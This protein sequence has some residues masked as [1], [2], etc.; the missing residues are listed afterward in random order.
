MSGAGVVAGVRAGISAVLAGCLTAA[1]TGCALWA[2]S[3]GPDTPEREEP[4]PTLAA[5]PPPGGW[6]DVHSPTGLVYSVPP[7]WEVGDPFGAP[8][9]GDTDLPQDPGSDWG[10]GYVTTANAIADRGYCAASGLSFRTL[11]GISTMLPGDAR[12]QAESASR[13]MADSI[14][15]RFTRNG[16]DVPVPEARS[17]GVSGV[18]AWYVSLRGAVR[19]PRDSCTPPTIRFDT[20]AVS[21]RATDGSPASI[22]FVLMSDEDEPGVQ[23]EEIIDAVVASLR[24][25]NSV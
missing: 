14:D 17:I 20:I 23:P 24:Y 22:V 3:P 7:D 13:A 10:S 11:S 6:Q 4:G 19:P 15:R 8:A 21:T 18:P 9:P 12:D 5:G 25:D 1:L 2:D 16:A